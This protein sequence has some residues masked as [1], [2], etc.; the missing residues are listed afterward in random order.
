M[1]IG[2]FAVEDATELSLAGSTFEV[3]WNE[4]LGTPG[5]QQS[6]TVGGDDADC[7][8]TPVVISDEC[9]ATG[10]V[11]VEFAATDECGN[12]STKTLQFKIVD[13]TPPAFSTSF[14][15]AYAACQD[16]SDPTD[17]T[18]VPL[19]ATDFCGD[20]TYSIEVFTMSGGCPNTYQ[21]IWTATDEC[22]N[23]SEVS[24]QYLELFD[25]QKSYAN[26]HPLSRRLYGG[27]R[28]GLHGSD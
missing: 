1:F 4:G 5:Q 14:S 9:G 7:G 20:V 23:I 28:C 10:M 15:Y 16:V 2:R 19:E 18:Q 8:P 21:R 11:D 25:D 26:L 3:T 24:E 17:P 22:G 12:T 13:T 6:V 27:C